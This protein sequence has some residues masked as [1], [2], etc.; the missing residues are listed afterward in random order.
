MSFEENYGR[1]TR[2][3]GPLFL[4]FLLLLF[5]AVLLRSQAPAPSDSAG[6]DLLH[7]P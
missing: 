6:R 4:A 5:V 1:V 3:L 7:Q 2:R